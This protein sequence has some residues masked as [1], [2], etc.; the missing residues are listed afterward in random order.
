PTPTSPPPTSTW[1]P[2]GG[3][4]ATYKV[5]STWSGG[6]Q[7]EVTVTAGATAI[8]GWTV[9]WTYPSGQ[10][11]NQAWNATLTTSGSAV[12]AKNVNYNGAL[13]AGASTTFGFL[14]SGSGTNPTPSCAATY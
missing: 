4:S 13:G 10:R 8:K 7:G 14:G 11:V 9:D 2:A 6:F 1:P 5:T 3:C 12:T